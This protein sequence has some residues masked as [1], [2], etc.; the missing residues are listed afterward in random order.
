STW[1]CRARKARKGRRSGCTRRS[2]DGSVRRPSIR[3]WGQAWFQ[4][5]A[6]RI[7]RSSSEPEASAKGGRRSLRSRFRLGPGCYAGLNQAC[8]SGT[9]YAS[10]GD[11]ANER[12]AAMITHLPGVSLP[13]ESTLDITTRVTQPLHITSFSARQRGKQGQGKRG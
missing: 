11:A 6:G 2:R 3:T 1:R 12:K 4:L 8:I 5:V 10:R 13:T 7:T 9:G